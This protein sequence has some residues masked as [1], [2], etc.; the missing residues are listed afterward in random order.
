MRI[1]PYTGSFFMFMVYRLH[2]AFQQ[3]PRGI[4]NA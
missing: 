3:I 2:E 1:L 4:I